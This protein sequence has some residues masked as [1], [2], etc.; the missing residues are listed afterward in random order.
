MADNTVTV[1]TYQDTVDQKFQIEPLGGPKDVFYYLDRFPDEIYHK[2]P[3]THLYKYMRAMLGESG[4]NWLRKNHLEARLLLEELGID[5][6]DLDQFF[7]NIFSFGRIVEESFDDD[8]FGVISKEVWEEIRAKNARYRNRALDFI[9]GA[10][11]GNTPFGM[12]LAAKA[13]LGHDVEII[14]NYKYLY[15]V[16]SDRPLGL[17]YF[18]KTTSTEEMIVLPRREVTDSGDSVD[19]LYEITPVDQRHLQEAVDQIRPQT[20]I[21][22]IADGRGIRAR[23]NWQTMY[24]TSEYTQVVR[25]VTGTSEVQ[26][27]NTSA[28]S[29]IVEQVEKES[30]RVAND[31]QHHY[32]GFHNIIAVEAS[33]TDIGTNLASGALADYAE[34]LLVTSSTELQDGK[35]VSFINGIYPTSYQ[36]LPGA[37][38]IRYNNTQWSS[39]SKT[40]EDT[41]TIHFPSIKAVNYLT[42]DISQAPIQIDIE[43]DAYDEDTSLWVPVTPLPPYSNILTA[44]DSDQNPW[45]SIGLSFANSLGN[46]IFTRSLKIHFT[47]LGSYAGSVQVKNLRAARSAA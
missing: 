10:R 34:P 38:P 12:R 35:A 42:F 4:V 27:P 41:L 19:D 26:W 43:Y 47:R 23:T 2:S 6:F 7:G 45:A 36:D 24:A 16:H 39:L 15:D 40:G 13:G 11:A 3:D 44:V 37:P 32:T 8:P 46:N 5:L 1:S 28:T 22:T 29:W 33:S 25:Y 21:M 18:G 31:L 20:T 17:T 30:L 9:N 14:E